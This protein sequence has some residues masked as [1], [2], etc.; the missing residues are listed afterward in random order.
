MSCYSDR[1][2]RIDAGAGWKM[3]EDFA[4]CRIDGGQA[5]TIRCLPPMAAD[6]HLSWFCKKS[7]CRGQNFRGRYHLGLSVEVDQSQDSHRG[8]SM[9][10]GNQFDATRQHRLGT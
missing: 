3:G 1:F 5:L 7:F 4:G 6:E 9:D 8:R 10:Q 2:I